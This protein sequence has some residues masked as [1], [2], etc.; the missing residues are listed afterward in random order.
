MLHLVRVTSLFGALLLL[1]AVVLAQGAAGGGDPTSASSEMT[2]MMTRPQTQKSVAGRVYSTRGGALPKAGVEIT[3]D[4]GAKYQYAV[5]DKAGDFRADFNLFDA[6]MSRQMVIT[7][8]VVHKGYQPAHKILVMNATTSDLSFAINMRPEAPED[9][10]LLS[11]NDLIKGLAPR[12][13]HLGAGDGLSPKQQKDYD[14]GV[15][16]F[17]NGKHLESAI[18]DLHKVAV[19]NPN[20]LR[21]RTMLGVAELKWDDWDDARAEFGEA[22]NSLI[23]DQKLGS[24]EPLLAY[25]TLV[26]W[27]HDPGKASTY[28][29][30][31]LTYSPKDPWVLQELGRTECQEMNWY[32]A[33]QTLK[34]ALDAGAGPEA[35]F[36]H[37]E[38]LLWSGTA[39]QATDELNVYLN[40]RDIKNMPPQVRALKEHIEERK[41]DEVAFR[42]AAVKAQAKGI[43]PVDYLHH[44]PQNLPDFQPIADQGLLKDILAATGKNVADLFTGL[45]NICS[46]EKIQHEKLNHDGKVDDSK[47]FKYRY[48]ALAPS[49]PWGPSIDEY[50]ADW[51]GKENPQMGLADDSMLTEGFVSAPLVFHPA[52]QSGSSFR[53]LG[54]QK[55][56]GRSAYVIAYAQE[57]AKTGLSGTFS[58]GNTTRLTYTQGLVWIDA[59]NYQI[60]RIVS[61]LLNPLPLVR[62]D[63]ETTDITFSEVQ[64][65]QV[66]Q[67]FWLPEKVT[68]TLK[69]NGR[70]YRNNHAYS[71]FLVS[72]VGENQ[73]IGKPKEAAKT[74]ED[75]IEKGPEG[76]RGPGNP[77]SSLVPQAN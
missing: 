44:P 20:C 58:F 59:D 40:G 49:H 38:A 10:N 62:L 7:L 14:K 47:E 43:V 70:Y 57:P 24:A 48:L 12:L 72:N 2:D 69:W 16:E 13:E 75:S 73:K 34:K 55:V 1:P 61:D 65:K 45:P 21:C 53:L 46:V 30:D 6:S 8:K 3:N 66:T 26:S 67:K 25:G 23:K 51:Q 9:P 39:R 52:Y 42:A 60:I 71:D 76:N 68:V 15:Q 32:S 11:L 63:R 5:T 31:A 33:D 77:A 27:K 54:R 18:I 28:F 37:A 41:K 19:A 4:S 22:V 64:F 36:M 50:R 17:Q 29:L 56:K 35:R 74:M